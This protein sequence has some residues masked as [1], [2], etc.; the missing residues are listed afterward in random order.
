MPYCWG[1]P[2][3]YSTAVPAQSASSSHSV[4]S[5]ETNLCHVVSF[6]D[7]LQLDDG[8]IF[9]RKDTQQWMNATFLVI[10]TDRTVWTDSSQEIPLKMDR[11]NHLN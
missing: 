2:Q 3:A 8:A 7:H 5:F 10:W 9:I 1:T 6:L 11:F 4:L